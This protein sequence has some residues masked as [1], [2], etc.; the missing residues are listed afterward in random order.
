VAGA[1]TGAVLFVVVVV[2]VVINVLIIIR[3]VLRR[4]KRAGD[5]R[6]TDREPL[7]VK[8]KPRPKTKPKPKPPQQ[9][10]VRVRKQRYLV[11]TCIQRPPGPV[12]NVAIPYISTSIKGLLNSG[13]SLTRTSIIRNLSDTSVVHI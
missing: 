1:V 3:V 8:Y 9:E 7:P 10:S 11:T 13:T 2:V 4:R 5:T 12:P 6:V